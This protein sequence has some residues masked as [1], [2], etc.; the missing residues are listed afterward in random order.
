MMGAKDI[1]ILNMAFAYALLLLT[2][3][4]FRILKVNLY[5]DTVIAF[6]RMTVQ[7][8]LVG[9]YL[10]AIFEYNNGF[11]NFFYILLMIAVANFSLLKNS[12]LKL[13]LFSHTFPALI[14]SLGFVLLY[15][16]FLVYVPEPRFDATYLVPIAGMLLGNSMRRT[17]ITV[18]RFYSSIKNDFEGF[19]SYVTMGAR[20][21]EAILPY[22]RTAY[23][24]GLAPALANTATIG[25][26]FL[27]GMMTGQI[28][29]GSS[30]LT[31][32]KYQITISIAIFAATEIASVLSIL[33][34]LRKGFDSYGFLKM[35]IFKEKK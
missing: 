2:F 6:L 20:V 23:R 29:G 12:G 31:A 35:S 27:P 16:L 25:I 9:L 19:A 18:E 8:F 14:I 32:I 34:S 13:I 5:K 3:G 30:P 17:I 28:L 10:T 26:V 7:L 24:A 11:L 4:I 15:F 1:P 33:F 22:L 21:E